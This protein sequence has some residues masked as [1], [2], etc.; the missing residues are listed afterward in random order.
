[1]PI[2][3]T[4]CPE[5]PQEVRAAIINLSQIWLVI[6][7]SSHY[8]HHKDAWGDSNDHWSLEN[9]LAA[10]LVRRKR[11]KLDQDFVCLNTEREDKHDFF[12]SIEE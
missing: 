1:M 9:V 4:S 7:I 2:P 5:R 10:R 6:H 8:D 11:A 12:L 3:Q